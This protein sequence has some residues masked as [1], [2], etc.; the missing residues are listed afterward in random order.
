MIIVLEEIE[1]PRL[2]SILIHKLNAQLLDEVMLLHLL[3]HSELLQCEPAKW[4]QRLT[5]VIAGH[6][7]FLQQENPP[8]FFGQ[9]CGG[10]ATSRAGTDD[11]DIVGRLRNHKI[12]EFPSISLYALSNFFGPCCFWATP[13]QLP[14]KP[15][16]QHSATHCIDQRAP[17]RWSPPAI[18]P[19]GNP[20]IFGKSHWGG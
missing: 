16:H 1:G 13:P 3:K 7:L 10:G 19:I 8:S 17:G 12:K 20:Q 14:P 4:H 11:N 5:D 18:P 2:L 15:H 9:Q 6:L